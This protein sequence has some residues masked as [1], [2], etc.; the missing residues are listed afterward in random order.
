MS[1]HPSRHNIVRADQ[2]GG[3]QPD[4]ALIKRGRWEHFNA[5]WLH[6]QAASNF[7]VDL[8]LIMIDWRRMTCYAKGWWLDIDDDDYEINTQRS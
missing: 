6:H 7:A 8:E 3:L 1:D 2:T 5:Y 4:A